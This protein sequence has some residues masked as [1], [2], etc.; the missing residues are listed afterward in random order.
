[1]TNREPLVIKD[2]RYPLNCGT[3]KIDS[4]YLD[5]SGYVPYTGATGNVDLGAYNLTATI[6]NT[7]QIKTDTVTATDFL[8]TTGSQKTLVLGT[9]VYD[10]IIIPITKTRLPVANF[11]AWTSFISPNS[12]YTFGVND[13]VDFQFEI[14]HTYKE[15]T[16]IEVHLHGAINGLEGTDKAIKFQFDYTIGNDAYNGSGIGSVFAN[17]A[18]LSKEFVIPA[19]T[20]DKS[21]FFID[22]GNITGTGL[23]I[24]AQ[25]VCQLKRITASGTAPSA[26]PFICTVGLHY[27][28]DTLGSRQISTK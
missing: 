27:Q 9:P 26:N 17:N 18:T 20:T 5:L 8:I 25:V 23:K 11:P 22:I 3:D 7:S 16:D 13:Y 6:V 2:G 4:Q 28:I 14:P 24:G 21:G 19:N 15:G 12:I 10:D 1:M